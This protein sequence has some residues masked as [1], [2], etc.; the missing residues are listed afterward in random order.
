MAS[1]TA[2]NQSRWTLWTAQLWRSH[3]TD[4]ETRQRS[5][6]CKTG[7]RSSMS[8]DA[9]RFSIEQSRSVTGE[10][11]LHPSRFRQYA[12]I[13]L[14]SSDRHSSNIWVRSLFLWRSTFIRRRM[15][16]LKS[17][18]KLESRELSN[19][20]EDWWSSY[21]IRLVIIKV[22]KVIIIVIIIT[23]IMI[24]IVVII[25]SRWAYELRTHPSNWW[26]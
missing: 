8:F 3:Q 24:V 17:T 11:D 16:S 4:A 9:V 25:Y 26:K 15:L 10:V 1:R 12:L 7:Y 21:S 20:L 5:G 6:T 13:S 19:V 18:R 22:T 2:G 14:L 23:K